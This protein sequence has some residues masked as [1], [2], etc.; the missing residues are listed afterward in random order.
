MIQCT[1]DAVDCRS[2]KVTD[3]GLVHPSYGVN[4]MGSTFFTIGNSYKLTFT[5]SLSPPLQLMPIGFAGGVVLTRLQAC[6]LLALA[7]LNLLPPVTSVSRQHSPSGSYQQLTL[8][9][10]L[11]VGFY[12]S[13][14]T[15]LLCLLGYFRR[16]MEAEEAEEE[17]FLSMR[18]TVE[19]R[20]LQGDQREAWKECETTLS[21]FEQP[22]DGLIEDAHGSLQVDFA[23]EYI[24]GGVLGMGNVQV[25]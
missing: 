2:Y 17:E 22:A 7:F 9:A 23:N 15:K 5:V 13:Q 3:Y 1:P 20:Q 24:G 4:Q 6:C 19:R 25:G 18:I 8:A 10:I 14:R 21:V 11:T 12:R 16:V